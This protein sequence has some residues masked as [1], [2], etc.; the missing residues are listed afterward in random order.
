MKTVFVDVDT[1]LDFMVPSGALYVPGAE[2][3][4]PVIARLNRFAAARGIPILATVDAHAENDPEFQVW[5]PHCIAGT[6]G[7]RK[8]DATLP[9]F[10]KQVVD[11]GATD[12]FRAEV[13]RL[14]ADRF[15]LYGVVTEYCVKSAAQALLKAGKQVEVITD[16][17]RSI[18]E[19]QGNLVLRELAA[20]GAT[21][22]TAAALLG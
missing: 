19:E 4:I 5:P 12:S 7:Q 21:L 11:F 8:V 9:V 13:D 2:L 15:V 16:A 17:I 6:L 18:H 22:T 14:D 10:E 20:A 3:L 1:Q